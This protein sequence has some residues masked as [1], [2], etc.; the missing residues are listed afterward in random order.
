M[1]PWSIIGPDVEISD[2]TTIGAHV[3]ISGPTR[4]GRHNRI[5][6]FNS[7]GDAAQDKKYAGEASRL[8]IGDRN[9]VREFGT[10]NR[11]TDLGGGVTRI[12]DD[13]WI[14]AYVHV[15]HDCRI[16]NGVVLANATTLAGHVSVDDHVSFG[17]FTVVHQFCE[18][19]AYSFTAMGSVVFKDVPPFVTVSGN[20]ARAHGL[21][22]VGLKRHGFDV[23]VIAEL[24]RAYKAIYKQGLTVEQALRSLDDAARRTEEVGSL[25][26]FVSGSNRG[27][28]R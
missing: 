15:A 27:I 10:F 21:N 19:G 8:E 17:A 1:G 24:R 6:Q 9:V 5:H 3:V 25:C 13:N 7:I 16:G 28:V 12:G 23:G 11:G 4:I 20:G 2:G 14:M 18:I 22:I 26:R